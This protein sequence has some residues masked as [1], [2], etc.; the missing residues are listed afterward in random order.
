MAV[1]SPVADVVWDRDEL[2]VAEAVE[3]T[4][5]L[6]TSFTVAFADPVRVVVVVPEGDAES[7]KERVDCSVLTC[8]REP[9]LDPDDVRDWMGA[10]VAA[11]ALDDVGD[12]VDAAVADRDSVPLGDSD[13]LPVP[14]WVLA[15][16]GCSTPV[17]D[18]VVVERCV[19]V[20]DADAESD[21]VDNA[22]RVT[23]SVRVAWPLLLLGL[24]DKVCVPLCVLLILGEPVELG[25]A[26]SVR[27][28][29]CG[30]DPLL[31]LVE[32]RVMEGLGVSEV[33]RLSVAES[34]EPAVVVRVWR[35]VLDVDGDAV[36]VLTEV[37]VFAVDPVI[38]VVSVLFADMEL[39]L[40]SMEL[41]VALTEPEE[42]FDPMVLVGRRTEPVS[43]TVAPGVVDES[44]DSDGLHDRMSD[45]VG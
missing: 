39:L 5:E 2:E 36:A 15:T 30:A 8:V 37:A 40:V 1:R 32:E 44:M 38:L 24:P 23:V 6:R 12:A 41:C 19:I 9:V 20:V 18:H 10:D 3:T 17:L 26:V 25:D 16:D 21:F 11:I 35:P 27:D 13:G 33:D 42:L 34:D 4:V 29:V 43:V 28:S 31:A 7:V 14:E 22:V 45:L